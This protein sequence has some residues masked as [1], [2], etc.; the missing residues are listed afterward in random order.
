MPLAPGSVASYNIAP[1]QSQA[2]L[3]L[4]RK[5]AYALMQQGMSAE[6]VQHWAQGLARLAQGAMGGYELYKADQGDQADRAKTR[7]IISEL[8]GTGTA[9]APSGPVTP[10]AGDYGG[11]IS[12]IESGGKYDLLGPVTKT[13]DRAY[14]KYQVMGA[15]VPEWSKE[16]LGKPLTPQQFTQD[17][18]AQDA[19]FKAKFDQYVQKYGPE[20]AARAWFAGE[21]GMNDPNRKDQLGTTVAGYGQKFAQA[22]GG[23]QAPSA[24][25]PVG[26]AVNQ[27]RG[28]LTPDRRSQLLTEL[29]QTRSGAPFAQVQ[30]G[31]ELEREATRVRNLT[32]EEKLAAPPG[33]TQVKASGEY[34]FPPPSTNVSLNAQNTGESAYAKGKAEDSLT[35]E[36]SADTTLAERQR[37][38]VFKS[39]VSDFKTGKMAP[40]QA[41]AGAWADAL[42]VDPK[43]MEKLGVPPNA[44]MNGQLIESL[45]NQMTLGMIGTKG[46]E[47]G[48]PANNFSDADRAFLSKTAPGL[49]RMPGGNLILAE[50]K[51]RGLDRQLEKVAMWDDYR[52][53]KKDFGDFERDWRKKVR[54]EPSIFADVPDMIK[55]LVQPQGPSAPAAA[56]AATMPTK[57]P[58]PVGTIEQGHRFKG[59]DPAKRENW[60]PIS[61]TN[62]MQNLGIRG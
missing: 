46:G 49:A 26:A 29:Y 21:G 22:L 44:A 24:Q 51:S 43:I 37:L 54:S 32:P 57:A 34:I 42:G 62:T 6:P 12:S 19:I 45:S 9:A 52:S 50:I 18:A 33:A 23:T 4:Q 35:L 60:E 14:G 27:P 28:G 25:A 55:N 10:Q 5:I 47:G 15:N 17:S 11:A 58:P 38:E 36:R 48:M 13:G 1:G 30:F 61:G 39:L 53:Q 20:G 56:P 3:D 59:G 40:A 7:S 31:K 2:D 41:T 8:M 16:V